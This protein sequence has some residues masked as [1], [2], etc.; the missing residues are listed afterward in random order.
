MKPV[1]INSGGTLQLVC[2]LDYRFKLQWHRALFEG[3]G[4]GPRQYEKVDTSSSGGFVMT[5]QV[6]NGRVRTELKKTNVSVADAGS[7]KCSR[8]NHPQTSYAVDVNILQGQST[9]HTDRHV[10]K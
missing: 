6:N 2:E 10:S 8:T 1:Y 5:A 7:Y 3:Q 9:V 4:Q